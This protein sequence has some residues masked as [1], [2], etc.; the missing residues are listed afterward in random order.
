M[1]VL[2]INLLEQGFRTAALWVL[3]EN[4]RARGFYRRLGGVEVGERQETRAQAVLDEVAY[5]WKDLQAVRA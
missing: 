4:E 1:H 2:A 3:K 5:G